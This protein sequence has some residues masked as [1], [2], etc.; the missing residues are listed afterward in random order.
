MMHG[1]I[2]QELKILHRFPISKM[3]EGHQK[4]NKKYACAYKECEAIQCTLSFGQ[5]GGTLN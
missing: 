2:K 3:D 1:L 4:E 5:P